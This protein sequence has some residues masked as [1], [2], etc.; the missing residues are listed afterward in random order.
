MDA[1]FFERPDEWRAWL[2]EHVDSATEVWVGF[3]KKGSGR[4]SITWPEAVDEA[5]CFGWID[6]VRKGMDEGRYMIRCTPRR[7][8]SVWSAVNIARVGELMRQGR[9]QPA[10]IAAFA[11]RAEDKSR[12]YSYEQQ[13]HLLDEVAEAQFRASPA[14][15]EFFQGQAPSYRKA[16]IWWVVSAKRDQTR[17]TRLATLIEDSA[18][19]RR[20][21]HLSRAAKG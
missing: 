6:G 19:G 15:W 1:I 16:A 13:D 10:G 2:A 7:P 9:V 4:P 12:V 20:L 5:L 3:Y 8:G 14:A 18:R 11:R 17:S 21:A